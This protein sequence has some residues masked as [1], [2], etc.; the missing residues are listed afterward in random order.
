M[1]DELVR[2]QHWIVE[3]LQS[4]RALGR[5]AAVTTESI[6]HLTGNDRLRPVDQ[7]EIYREQFW[8]RH[9]ASLVEDFPGVGGIL[10][11]EEWQGLVESYLVAHGP[12][13]WTLRDLG[14][15]FPEHIAQASDLSHRAVCH[16]MA[17]LEWQYIELFDAP[18]AAPLDLSVLG[19]LPPG[20][21]ER[22]TFALNPALSLLTV[23][24]PVADLRMQLLD[25]ARTESVPIP[26]TQRQHL[27]LYRGANRRLYHHPLSEEGFVLLEELQR[28]LPLLAACERSLER[29]PEAG[30][31]LQAGVGRWFQ[32]WVRRGW[33]V[34]LHTEAEPP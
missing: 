26:D 6:Q 16:D 21:L 13:T 10:G 33:I 20:A 28:G 29:L 1:T 25:D 12:V 27:V 17:R 11:Q 19:A 3:Q 30:E 8:L 7:L 15:H 34:R 32:D 23:D 22:A 18:E 31:A 4:P 5:N 24:Y 9:T 2:L 14:R